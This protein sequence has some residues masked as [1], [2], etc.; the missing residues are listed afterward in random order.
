[1]DG[2]RWEY[3]GAGSKDN[4]AK[5][6]A[7]QEDVGGSDEV[8]CKAKVETTEEIETTRSAAGSREEGRWRSRRMRKNMEDDIRWTANMTSMIVYNKIICFT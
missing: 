5:M 7:T 1:M 3:M 8:P 4:T 2:S 6:G